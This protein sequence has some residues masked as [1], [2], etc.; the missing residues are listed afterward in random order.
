MRNRIL[1]TLRAPCGRLYFPK[2]DRTTP[3][4]L[5]ILLYCYLPL[6]RHDVESLSLL[7]W[8]WEGSVTALC[9]SEREE[10]VPVLD[11]GLN[12]P[13]SFQFLPLESQSLCKKHFLP[14]TTMHALGIP[15]QADR[16]WGTRGHVESKARQHGG[17]RTWDWR[18]L[19]GR[20]PPT[21]ATPGE[22]R[23]NRHQPSSQVSPEF[24]TRKLVSKL[25]WLF[26]YK[27]LE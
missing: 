7:P 3:P 1:F 22:A 5:C 12:Q 9:L 4:I 11:K 23:W 26:N 15:N 27:V 19:R 21:P 6:T 8:I 25:K 14:E 13:H 24:L 18:S 10:A 2:M 16:P 17:D 20:P